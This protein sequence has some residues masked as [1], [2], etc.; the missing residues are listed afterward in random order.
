MYLFSHNFRHSSIVTL[1]KIPELTVC[2][3]FNYFFHSKRRCDPSTLRRRLQKSSRFPVM[4]LSLLASS[5]LVASS[6]NT[7]EGSLG[8]HREQ[9]SHN[10][11]HFSPCRLGSKEE[12]LSR[13][14]PV[15]V[16]LTYTYQSSSISSSYTSTSAPLLN[17]TT[18]PLVVLAMIVLR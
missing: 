4:I 9:K 1:Y 10:K 17:C 8:C 14:P 11:R 5:E 12:N 18:K 7:N 13:L 16:S 6:R 2:F 3:I 15:E